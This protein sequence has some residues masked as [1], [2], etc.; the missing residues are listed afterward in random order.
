MRKGEEMNIR[1]LRSIDPDLFNR[2]NS[3]GLM[4]F[5]ILFDATLTADMLGEVAEKAGI[6]EEELINLAGRAQMMA[7]DGLG[8]VYS[9][10]LNVVG[11]RSVNQLSRCDPFELHARIKETAVNAKVG[12]VPNRATVEHWIEQAESLLDQDQVRDNK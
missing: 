4:D 7:I 5:T 2:L 9:E 1:Q 3:I 11:I 10:L 6:D 8:L 12:R